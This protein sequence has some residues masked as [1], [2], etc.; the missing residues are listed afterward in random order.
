ML[1]RVRG[2]FVLALVAGCSFENGYRLTDAPTDIMPDVIVPTWQVD[3]VSKKGVPAATFEWDGLLK[4]YGVPTSAP[5][6]LWLMQEASGSLT[7]SLGG[8]MLDPLNGPSYRD[9][10]LGW[11]RVAVGTF[12]SAA[13]QGFLSTGAG[14]LNGQSY[15]LLMYVAVVSPP[16]SERSLLGIGGGNDHRY[17]S[18]T[19]APVFK[20]TGI[21]VTPTSGMVNPMAVGHPIVLKINQQKLEYIVYTDQEKIGVTWAGTGGAAGLVMV[22]NAV[23]GTAAARYLYGAMWENT[24][25]EL[26]DADVKKLLQALGWTVNGY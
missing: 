9:S 20:G 13:N 22:G 5:D 24:K 25:A 15:L 10:I 6:H 1:P 17:V 16:A 7:D 2:L 21:G 19:T 3:V 26:E 11:S 12:D 18:L 4:A 8:V 14:Y 23:I